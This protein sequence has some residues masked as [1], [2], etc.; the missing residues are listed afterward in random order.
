MSRSCS[1][2][3]GKHSLSSY[4]SR[5]FISAVIRD[6]LETPFFV[7]RA[8]GEIVKYFRAYLRPNVILIMRSEKRLWFMQLNQE[9]NVLKQLRVCIINYPEEAKSY[10]FRGHAVVSLVD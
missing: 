1:L 7:T 3:L 2:N 10:A 8:P 5:G 9:Y 6:K 4:F